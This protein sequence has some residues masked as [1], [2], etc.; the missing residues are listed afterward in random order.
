MIV[1][2]ARCPAVN[3]FAYGREQ[4]MPPIPAPKLKPDV[5]AIET[6]IRNCGM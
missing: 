1:L 6:P 2:R 3:R 5:I 4:F